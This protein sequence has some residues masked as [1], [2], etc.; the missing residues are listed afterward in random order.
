MLKGKSYKKQ[1]NRLVLGC[2]LPLKEKVVR[3]VLC[4]KG[5]MQSSASTDIRWKFIQFCNGILI[6][7]HS[8]HA[9]ILHNDCNA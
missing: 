8:S 9:S 6:F 5:F 4:D 1:A 3:G 2:A 7:M